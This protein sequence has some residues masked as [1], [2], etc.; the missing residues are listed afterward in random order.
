MI[1][2]RGVAA[3][4]CGAME[5]GLLDWDRSAREPVVERA[6]T[7]DQLHELRLWHQRHVHD[8]PLEKHV[9][10]TV[11]TLW[12]MGWVGG[13][14][15]LLIHMRWAAIVCLALLFLPGAY[16]WL[17]RKLHRAHVLRCDWIVALR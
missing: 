1:F 5:R 15:A 6:M 10:D 2:A 7:L 17:R 9:W 12:M 4:A 13:P 16:V 3:T 11:L 14:T 8:R